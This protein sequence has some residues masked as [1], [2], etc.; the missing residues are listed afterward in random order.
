[1]FVWTLIGRSTR[2]NASVDSV[3][4]IIWLDQV[5]NVHT[6]FHNRI[7]YNQSSC[8][9]IW[10]MQSVCD[11]GDDN[12][13]DFTKFNIMAFGLWIPLDVALRFEPS[14]RLTPKALLTHW[15]TINLSKLKLFD[16][17]IHRKIERNGFNSIFFSYAAREIRTFP[18]VIYSWCFGLFKMNSELA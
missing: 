12:D 10:Y 17:L 16:R 2:K 14:I 9:F 18:F 1:M 8:V 15:N 5:W 6:V 3:C 11:D 7:K 4:S 13:D